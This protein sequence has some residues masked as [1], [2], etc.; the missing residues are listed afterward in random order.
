MKSHPFAT[1]SLPAI[2]IAVIC[3]QNCAIAQQQGSAND[4]QQPPSQSDTPSPV[5]AESPAPTPSEI[6]SAAP[7]APADRP[8]VLLIVGASGTDEYGSNFKTWAERWQAAATAAAASFTWIGPGSP[9]TTSIAPSP[10]AENTPATATQ[11]PAQPTDLELIK[12]ALRTA[13]SVTTSQPLWIIYIGHGTF[14]QKTAALNLRGPDL[15]DAEFAELLKPTSRPLITAVCASCS[16]PFINALSAPGRIIISATKD[17]NQLQYSRFGDAFSQAIGNLDADGD[18]DGQTSLLEAWLFASRRTAEFYKTEGR[19]AS[20]H[21]LLEDNGDSRGVRSELFEGV[22]PGKN[23]TADQPIDGSLAGK[24]WLIRS[25]EERLLTP[26]QQVTRDALEARL[27]ALKS[28][29]SEIDEAD[30]L[31]Q[32]EEILL[33]LAELYKAAEQQAA[34]S[35]PAP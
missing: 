26:D 13:S 30:Y 23:V 25:T 29:R 9:S 8:E 31:Q 28:R 17:G 35:P 10:T 20:E 18:R 7:A 33:P 2:I 11:T 27:E 21:S 32:L 6:S 19:L 24:T 5:S 16:A 22:R 3:I 12:S 14:D 15:T 34:T 1:C 4:Q